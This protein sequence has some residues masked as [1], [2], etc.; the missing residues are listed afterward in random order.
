MAPTGSTFS[1]CIN[2][3]LYKSYSILNMFLKCHQCKILNQLFYFK[4]N[5][6]NL[7]DNN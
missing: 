6:D 2:D 5:F 7:V 4:L 1:E 3:F